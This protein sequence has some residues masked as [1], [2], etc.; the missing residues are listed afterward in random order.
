MKHIPA[1]RG[2][3]LAGVSAFA[4]TAIA[5][6]ASAQ[7]VDYGALEELYGEAVTTSVTGKPQK[8]SE[9]PANLTIITQ[10]DIR[11]SGTNNIPDIL[12][13][14]AGIDIRRYGAADADV[15]IRGYDERF[16]KSAPSL[17]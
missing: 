10:D 15:A 6:N 7:S 5:R 12:Q 16:C 8:A 4:I 14:V 11:R 1:A 13:F 17:A 2:L 3:L 9:A